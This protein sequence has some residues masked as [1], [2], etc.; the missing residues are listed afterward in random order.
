MFEK[1]HIAGL[2]SANL[3]AL[4]LGAHG[5]PFSILGPHDVEKGRIL[6]VYAPGAW[7]MEARARADGAVLCVLDHSQTPGL[8][9]GL[10]AKAGSGAAPVPYMLVIYWPG[11]VEETEDPYSFGLLLSGDELADIRE[12]R[13]LDLAERLGALPMTVDGAPGVRFAVWAPNARRVA[14]VGSFNRWDERRHPMRMRHEAGV[15]ELFVPRIGEGETYKFAI[16][17]PDGERLPW[18]ADPC[19]RR[20]ESPPATASVVARPMDHEWRD[21][22]WMRTRGARQGASAPVSIYEVHVGSWRKPNGRTMNWDEL[23]VRL[24]PYVKALGFTHVELTPIAEFPFGGSWGYQA[25][26]LFAPSARY[27]DPAGLARFVDR[28]HRSGLGVILDWT[29]AHFPDDAHGL[30]R[31][32]GTA[33]YEH[34]DPREGRH[35]DWDTL[36]YN[37]SRN[38]VQGFLLAS[39]LH[40]LRTFHI[41][42]LR[43]DAVSSMLYRDY[44]RKDGEWLPNV[45][46]GREN[47]EAVALLRRINREVAAHCP[48][49]VMI[50]EESTLWRGVTAPESEGGLGFTYKWSLGWMNDSLRY[51]RRDPVHRAWHHDQLTGCLAF[52]HQERFVLPLS[53]D[54]TAHGKGSLLGKMPGAPSA[55]LANLRAYYAFMWTHPGKKLLFMG[56]ELA[57]PR[58]WDH[59]SE[60]DWGLL[61]EPAHLGVLALVRDLNL[62]Y[63]DEP[64]LHETDCDAAGFRWLVGD[65]AAQ[66]VFVYLR[67]AEGAADLLVALNMTPVTRSDYR[68]GVSESGL[69]R[70]ILNTD[71]HAYGGSDIGNLGLVATWP[72]PAHGQEQ[73]LSLTLPPLAAVILRR[74]PSS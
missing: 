43:V 24:V 17:G 65:D 63:R 49:A 8:F 64:A 50:A 29:P 33:L 30:A 42:G 15:W 31:F 69:W 74:E 70:E 28:C 68:I 56:G 47:L 60:I 18:K 73:S 37:F 34:A 3:R 46:G 11:H 55:A 13:M 72:E 4:E 7:R 58:E 39:A 10:L 61:D 54:E 53:H 57:H 27:G 40:W 9:S 67:T 26:S 6:R 66:S 22:D 59:D 25:L 1:P 71:S 48:G 45:H 12:G 41:D 2:D 19:A 21:G 20:T 36:I 5:D 44:S 23:A 35:P 38:E 16:T 32:D 62:C 51:M 14:V 52:A